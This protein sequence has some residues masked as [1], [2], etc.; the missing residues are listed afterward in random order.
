M[1]AKWIGYVSDKNYRNI[2]KFDLFGGVAQYY[3][4]AF[5]L[6]EKPIKAT[7]KISA[8]GIFKVFLNGKSVSE[9]LFA[10]G[11]TN[12][13]KRILYRVYDV[14]DLIEEKN[15]VAVC[16]G[17]G[18]YAGYISIKG[19][20]VY[21]N[22]PLALFAELNFTFADGRTLSVYT[23]EAWKA[24]EGAIRQND[25]L[26]GE[27]YDDRMPHTEISEFGF[28]DGEWAN[29]E[30][31]ED[32]SALLD[33]YGYEPII[34][35]ER[36][37]ARLLSADGNKYI[38]DFG[39]NFA[40]VVT[41]RARGKSGSKITIRHGE[42]LDGGALYTKNLRKAKATDTLIL[43]GRE[44]E[45]T[46]TMTYHGFRFAEITLSDGAEL[47]TVEG[48]AIYN[49]LKPT[50]KVTTSNGLVNK[51]ISNVVWGMKSNFVD[52]PTD[53]PQ[54]NERLGWTGDTQVFSRSAAYFADCRR[55]YGKYLET[56]DDDREGGSI[57]DVIPYFGVAGFDRAFWRDVA[58]VLPYNLYEIYG[59]KK[60]AE[61]YL[62]IIKDFLNLQ[63]KN[64]KN[65]RWEKCFYNDW[66]N[67]EEPS[68]EAL[69]AT[70]D[71]AFCFKLAIKLLSELGVDCA[72]YEEFLAGVKKE[73]SKTFLRADGAIENGTQTVYALAYRADLIDADC[74]AK[75]LKEC[76]EKRGNHIHSGFCGI[77]FIL[78]VLCDLG[79]TNLAYE[80][81]CKDTFPSWG[82]SIV[83]GATTVWERWDSY[84]DGKGFQS[85]TM[86]SFNHYS[87]GS[88]GEWFFEYMLGIKPAAAGFD[89]V[90]IKPYVDRSG[91]V[92]SASGSFDSVNGKICVEWEKTEDGFK[93]AVTKPKD[94]NADFRFDNIV[95]IVQ[96]GN[97]TATFDKRAV[98]TEIYFN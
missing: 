12:Y 42:M 29:A 40:G 77:R 24:S 69:L 87:L 85:E 28:D 4:K 35:H 57:P 39:Q 25:F 20:N 75:G 19:R 60:S 44:V 10:P 91:K 80:L 27:V 41:M 34:M 83:N 31:S 72:V 22:Y 6:K 49:D 79:L 47:L 51:L 7:L 76:F 30:I 50:G 90:V 5:E 21:G 15:A 59:D 88:C 13:N 37:P 62:P 52:V 63:M 94:L 96:D 84:V 33:G 16:V 70:C 46:P 17:D 92:N 1:C 23:D 74:A 66:L 95:K 73:F 78:P 9:E 56:L 8:L 65:F 58:V 97:V 3:R 86:N 54:R 14:T 18:W 32:K 82:Y 26:C 11:W 53:C 61:K 89:G 93:C 38:Y 64:A 43:S 2:D 48:R 68:P 98:C 36:F 71:N 45:Y 55:F 81:I 67:I